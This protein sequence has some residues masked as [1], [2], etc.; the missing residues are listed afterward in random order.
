MRNG[1]VITSLGSPQMEMCKYCL[2]VLIR[3]LTGNRD[4]ITEGLREQA[5]L[6]SHSWKKF[7]ENIPKSERDDFEGRVPSIEGLI[8]M[9]HSVA[10]AWENKRTASKS[11]KF[12]KYFVRFCETLDAHSTMLKLLPGGSEYVSLFTGTLKT[13]INVR[14]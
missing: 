11:G 10:A 8:E 14:R 3:F 12:M 1:I 7:R 4:P 6:L 13:I 9:V 5:F 2:S